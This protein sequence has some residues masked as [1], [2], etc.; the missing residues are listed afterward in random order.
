VLSGQIGPR[1][2]GYNP[3]NTMTA[4]EA[5]DYHAEQVATFVD[6]EADMV[7]AITMNTVNEAIGVARAADAAAIPVAISFTVETDGRLPTG[8]TLKEA[9]LAVDSATGTVPA[10]YMVNCAH[11]THFGGALDTS[12]AWIARI[13][14]LRANAS[15]MSHAELDQATAL[16]D[17]NP[18]ELGT[19]HAEILKR[20]PHIRVL[21][22]CCGTDHRHVEAIGS[23]CVGH[24]EGMGV[25][26]HSSKDLVRRPSPTPPHKGEGLHGT[27]ET[28]AAIRGR[29][30]G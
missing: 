26:L 15:K 24:A 16:D 9:I 21:G 8:E 27:A 5:E 13:R 2:D 10:Y 6:T 20:L 17:G 12:E 7:T 4:A 18:A 29:L 1:G 14:G 25:G 19:E 30:R 23:A 3:S 11:P 22:G 28:P